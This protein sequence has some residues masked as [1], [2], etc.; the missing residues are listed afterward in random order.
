MS[1]PLSFGL[2]ENHYQSHNLSRVV[3]GTNIPPQKTMEEQLTKLIGLAN[4]LRKTLGNPKSYVSLGRLMKDEHLMIRQERP[5]D[6]STCNSETLSIGVNVL[7]DILASK[8]PNV[9]PSV[10]GTIA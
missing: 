8:Q 4:R 7:D 9:H 1:S 5:Q 10:G 3:V 6:S 2:E